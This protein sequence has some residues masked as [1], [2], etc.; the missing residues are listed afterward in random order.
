MMR[1]LLFSFFCFAW[2]ASAQSPLSIETPAERFVVPGEFATFVFRVIAS[3]AITVQAEV[4]SEQGWTILR[5]P[6]KLELSPGERQPIAVT[7][8]IPKDAEAFTS[9]V[10]SLAI[11]TSDLRETA[12]VTLSVSEL[13]DL[14]LET[15]NEVILSPDGFTVAIINRGNVAERATLELRRTG[16]LVEARELELEPHAENEETFIVMQEGS[17]TL[18]LQSANSPDIFKALTVIRFGVPEP[19]PFLL[20]GEA[21]LG[22][23]TD[24]DWKT[25]VIMDGAL[26]DFSTF[27]ARFTAPEWRDSFAEIDTALWNARLG[28]GYTNLYR[29]KFPADFGLAGRYYSAPWTVASGFGWVKESKFSGYTLGNYDDDLWFV[30]AGLGVRSGKFMGAIHSTLDEGKT[31]I[32]YDLLQRDSVL[33]ASLEAEGEDLLNGVV[34][35]REVALAANNL[36]TPG[37]TLSARATYQPE[38]LNFSGD[39]SLPLTPEAPFDFNFGVSDLI[40]S[41]LQGQ[42]SYSAQAGYVSSF[43]TLRYYQEL[44]STWRTTNQAGVLWDNE[45]FGLSLDSFWSQTGDDFFSVDAQ[46][47]YYPNSD[48]LRGK[49]GARGQVAIDTVQV[50]ANGNWNLTENNV[51]LSANALWRDND[52]RLEV[53]AEATYTYAESAQPWALGASITGT[54]LFTLDVPEDV[55][56]FA[57]GRRLGSLVGSLKAGDIPIPGVELTIE[58]YRFETDEAGEFRADLPPGTYKVRIDTTTVPI[59]YRLEAAEATVEVGLQR[60]TVVNFQALKTAALTGRILQDSDADGVPD[61]PPAGVNAQLLLTDAEGLRR[62]LVT[63]E[64]GSYEVRGLVPGKITLSLTNLPLGSKG[65]GETVQTVLLE[66]GVV[67]D[68]TFLVQPARSTGKSFGAERLR[69]RSVTPEVER[70]P[71]GLAPLIT[72]VVGGEAE[73]VVLT[74][75]LET[76]P[77][78]FNGEAWQG[79]LHLP[80][81]FEAGVFSFNAVARQAANE[82]SRRGRIIIDSEADALAL[83]VTN[84]ARPNQSLIVE[85]T[86]YFE[87]ERITVEH[88]F[89]DPINLSKDPAHPSLWS[90]T[91]TIPA[92]AEDKTYTLRV[93]AQQSGS[94]SFEAEATFRV[95]SP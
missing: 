2:L 15:P 75:D 79:R 21:S 53:A 49:V 4:R 38:N 36:F 17:Y 44:S 92:N 59:I 23:S 64:D 76:L 82:V 1:F 67:T 27:G 55:T 25:D 91:I 62:N 9:E 61:T 11:S 50:S 56:T 16:D 45:G 13:H 71:P 35:N 88:P 87:A 10:L 90:A 69:I 83:E 95:L 43:A 46:F 74:T 85:V 65:I 22:I 72:V 60:E 63:R 89:G 29:I 33:N 51:G 66:A 86:P 37:A 73:A 58:R 12:S 19:E 78:S 54:Y 42:L 48:L 31:A 40:P 81:D 68:T 8:A 32:R 39:L 18:S 84:P 57:G 30:S 52:W 28:Q 26:S 7:L 3:E 34:A 24:G 5:Q 80:P 94:S 14:A 77:L 6:G 47:V 93:N 41:E 70:V 20:V